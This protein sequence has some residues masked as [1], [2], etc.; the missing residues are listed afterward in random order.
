MTDTEAA[1]LVLAT[2]TVNIHGWFLFKAPANSARTGTH[3]QTSIASAQAIAE[4][5][6]FIVVSFFC[7]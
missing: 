7:L 4:I 1:V 3:V 6:L 5:F 2:L